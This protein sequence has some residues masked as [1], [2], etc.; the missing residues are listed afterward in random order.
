MVI[1]MKGDSLGIK[2]IMSGVENEDIC[3]SVNNKNCLL[4]TSDAA[5]EQ[6]IV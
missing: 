1:I 5:D 3:N 4:Y 6:Y 2:I